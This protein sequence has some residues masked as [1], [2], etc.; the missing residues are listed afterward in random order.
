VNKP[1]HRSGKSLKARLAIFFSWLAGLSAGSMILIVVAALV[2]AAIFVRTDFFQSHLR[3]QVVEAAQDSLGI[4]ITYKKADVDVLSLFPKLHFYEVVLDQPATKVHVEIK[5]VSISISMFISLPLLLV[6]KIYIS[7]AEIAG[8]TYQLN[9]ARVLARWLKRLQPKSRFIPSQFTTVVR[10][11]RFSDFDLKLNLN[12]KDIVPK[13]LK[14]RLFLDRF[15]VHLG[16]DGVLLGG[17]LRYSGLQY[18]DIKLPD[19]RLIVKDTNYNDGITN[20][21]KLRLER[22]EDYFEASG[23]IKRWRNPIVALDLKASLDLSHYFQSEQL[24]GK[25]HGEQQFRGPWKS[26]EGQGSVQCKELHYKTKVFDSFS[27]KEKLNLPNIKL[28]AVQWRAGQESGSGEGNIGLGLSADSNLKLKFQHLQLGSYVGIFDQRLVHWRGDI[29]G[30]ANLKG[31]FWKKGDATIE[32]KFEL[33]DYEVRDETNDLIFQLPQAEIVGRLKLKQFTQGNYTASVKIENGIFGCGSTWDDKSYEMHWDGMLQGGQVGKLF[34]FEIGGDGVLHGS[35]GGQYGHLVLDLQPHLTDFF[36]SEQHFK[37]VSGHLMLKSRRLFGDPIN[38]EGVS[39]TGGL[40]FPKSRH[41]QV[42]FSDFQFNFSQIDSKTILSSLE[43]IKNLKVLPVSKLSGSGKLTG[44][45]DRPYG[46]GN[47]IASNIRIWGDRMLGRIA[48]TNWSFDSGIFYLTDLY[49]ETSKEGGGV[50]GSISFRSTGV[51]DFRLDGKKVR[52]SDWFLFFGRQLPFQGL[53]DFD[54]S[55]QEASDSFSADLKFFKTMVGARSL[56]DSQLHISAE[57]N[58]YQFSAE[59]FEGQMGI[60]FS[61]KT[62]SFGEAK[63]D[64]NDLDVSP[65]IRQLFD[66]GISLNV[67]GNGFCQVRFPQFLKGEKSFFRL[68]A[69]PEKF[70]CWSRF[71]PSVVT[72][73][74]VVLHRIDGFNL[75]VSKDPHKDLLWETDRFTLQTGKDELVVGGYFR[76]FEDLKLKINGSVSL[77]SVSYFLPFLSRS[78]GKLQIDGGWNKSGL[79]G[80]TF[81]SG[82]M[83]LFEDSPIVLRNV[84][85][86]L[87]A[88]NSVVDINQLSGDVREGNLSASGRFQLKGFDVDSALINIQLNSPLFEPEQSVRFRVSGPLTLK[89]DHQ[90]AGMSGKLSVFDGSFRKRI[91]LRTDLLKVFQPQQKK[92]EFFQQQ[93]S[94]LDTWGLNINMS[95]TEPFLI[96]NNITDGAVDFNINLL[97]TIGKPQLD[98]RVSLL[99]GKFN[100][101]NRSFDLTSGS[102]QFVNNVS[103][104]PRYDIRA[105]MEIDDYRVYITLQG[106]KDNQKILYSSDP[107]LTEKQI[108]VLVSSGI[109][110]TDQ[111]QIKQLD[112]TTSAAFAGLSFVTAKLQDTIEGALSTDLGIRRFRLFPAFYEETG[113]TELQLTVG[114]D[115]IPNRLEL[116]Y[117]NFVSVSGGHQVDLD[118]RVNR[119]ISLVGSWRDTQTDKSKQFGGD[120]GGDI[121]FRFEFD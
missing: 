16:A 91:N 105:E 78:E 120:L 70:D 18:G 93:E 61:S 63:L 17:T 73:G 111:N 118:L 19:G 74:S 90:R 7:R 40:Y 80:S 51:K 102:I 96:R 15:R 35:F 79:T 39:F 38:A 5:R 59:V 24:S 46:S 97:G 83:L 86:A 81:L 103:N 22:A 85:A 108:L 29:S 106:D 116:N 45:V 14:A 100:Y 119:N 113:R 121:I 4:K 49:L 50:R 26:L 10:E 8:L 56:K 53:T 114:T 6:K 92:Y 33:Q 68:F 94:Y 77:E 36:L 21:G 58:S 13:E 89:I 87:N 11:I 71:D 98:G 95:T 32:T 54:L 2:G 117:S 107:T 62:P 47:L 76:N 55:Y 37:N 115:L 30:H 52:I 20:I 110:P 31:N 41:R 82:G 75:N 109:P 43:E 3:D 42:S 66:N 60:D 9:D 27:A 48:K 64:F 44:V 112:A 1:S 101:F 57:R 88:R 65:L 69:A 23:E 34:Q 104:I 25:C 99:R 12:Q 28:S 72:R 67:N 84:T